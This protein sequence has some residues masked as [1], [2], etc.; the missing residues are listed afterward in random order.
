MCEL[1][2]T[3]TQSEVHI[4]INVRFPESEEKK[5]VRAVSGKFRAVIL[6][7]EPSDSIEKAKENNSCSFHICKPLQKPIVVENLPLFAVSV[8]GKI[9]IVNSLDVMYPTPAHMAGGL[10]L[11][12]R[13]WVYDLRILFRMC[14]GIVTKKC[15]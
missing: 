8:M 15:K 11:W 14:Y 7:G 4:S 2:Q 3:C 9:P 10:T 6:L 5:S 13:G 1:V 12:Q